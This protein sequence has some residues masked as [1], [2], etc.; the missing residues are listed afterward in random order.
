MCF[1]YLWFSWIFP[2]R[3]YYATETEFWEQLMTKVNNQSKLLI[4][5]VKWH[6]LFY[7]P[8][9]FDQIHMSKFL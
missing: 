2:M 5:Y 6:S 8:V 1:A 9:K 4:D 3:I 7:F